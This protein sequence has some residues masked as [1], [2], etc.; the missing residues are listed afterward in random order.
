MVHVLWDCPACKH[1]RD[2]FSVELRGLLGE[3]FKSIDI[4]ERSSFVVGCEL[5]EEKFESL[6][7]VV[8]FMGS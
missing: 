6:L 7:T 5:W 2:A 1:S 8:Q 4:V 3:S